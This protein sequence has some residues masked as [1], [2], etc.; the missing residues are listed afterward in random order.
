MAHFTEITLEE[1]DRFLKR[2]WRALHP[3]MS[4][5]RGTHVYD[6]FLSPNVM[7]RVWTT[8]PVHRET[9]RDVGETVIKVQLLNA[10]SGKPLTGRDKA[11]IVK[12]VEGWK[13]NLQDRIEKYVELYEENE[14]DY[15][16]RTGGPAPEQERLPLREPERQPEP[17]HQPEPLPPSAPQLRRPSEVRATFTKY[18]GDWCLRITGNVGPGDKVQTEKRDGSKQWLTVG[19]ILWRG[20]DRDTGATVMI[21]SIARGPRTASD[22]GGY[23]EPEESYSYERTT[24]V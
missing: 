1:M 18:Q 15:E 4:K 5:E 6:L 14:D 21:T 10:R 11:L 12:R 3:K 22:D 17:E 2:G 13:N 16:G 24:P 19:E 8:I 23:E 20:R 7:I 9:V